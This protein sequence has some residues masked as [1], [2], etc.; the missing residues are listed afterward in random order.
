MTGEQNPYDAARPLEVDDRSI[1]AP[2]GDPIT[3][4][5]RYLII[6]VSCLSILFWTFYAIAK[7]PW[8]VLADSLLDTSVFERASLAALWLAA[9]SFAPPL[10]VIGNLIGMQ[11]SMRIAAAVIILG[12]LVAAPWLFVDY[13]RIDSLIR[14]RLP[15]YIV[16]LLLLVGSVCSRGRDFARPG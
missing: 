16:G 11:R 12:W 9:L 3:L 13:S 7:Y 6:A 5:V 15:L 14:L 10:L 1:R 2:A 4:F 8:I